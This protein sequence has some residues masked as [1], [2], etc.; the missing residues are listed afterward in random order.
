[1]SAQTTPI[2]ARSPITA[3][4]RAE[5]DPFTYRCRLVQIAALLVLAAGVALISSHLAGV[6]GFDETLLWTGVG[7]AAAAALTIGFLESAIRG[8]AAPASRRAKVAVPKEG[9]AERS[10]KPA[11]KQDKKREIGDEDGQEKS[12][13]RAASARASQE[14]RARLADFTSRDANGR[15]ELLDSLPQKE[16]SALFEAWLETI[17]RE[18]PAVPYLIEV[19]SQDSGWEEKYFKGLSQRAKY[20]LAS[21]Y[22]L[23][24]TLLPDDIAK[25]IALAA[26]LDVLGAR[27]MDVDPPLFRDLM[28]AALDASGLDLVQF[29]VQKGAD[30]ALFLNHPKTL[31]DLTSYVELMEALLAGNTS[32]E[33]QAFLQKTEY[34]DS[35]IGTWLM[36]IEKE[37]P[38]IRRLLTILTDEL[39]ERAYTTLT[40]DLTQNHPN[41]AKEIIPKLRKRA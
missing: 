9:V 29:A 8:A 40:G 28:N 19:M 30:W 41:M 12:R 33:I 17:K 5:V 1:M 13:A 11:Q 37:D 10:A 32:P 15:K 3:P 36:A 35:I 20:L 14:A 22:V 2:A 24:L 26:P 21:K 27:A 31:R 25:D 38:R 4:K 39:S 18:D 7:L 6:V 16:R 23:S 34:L